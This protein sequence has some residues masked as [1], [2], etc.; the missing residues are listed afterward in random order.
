MTVPESEIRI[1]LRVHP[2]A[3]RNEV[4]GFADGVLQVKVSAPPVKGKANK[5]LI[6]FLSRILDVG[7]SQISIIKG[8]TSQNKVIAVGGLSREEIMGRL[9]YNQIA[10]S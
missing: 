7:R 4:M 3:V 10:K 6:D 1:P 9:S 2:N 8:H 5:E